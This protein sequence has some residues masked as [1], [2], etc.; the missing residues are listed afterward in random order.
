MCTDDYRK[1]RLARRRRE[2]ELYNSR[3]GTNRQTASTDC[4]PDLQAVDLLSEEVYYFLS[5]F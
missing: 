5:I 1:S 2:Q 3:F 4:L